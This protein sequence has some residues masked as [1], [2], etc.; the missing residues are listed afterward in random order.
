MQ[1]MYVVDHVTSMTDN[2]SMDMAAVFAGAGE[3][4]RQW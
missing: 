4:H 2:F 1:L 3:Q